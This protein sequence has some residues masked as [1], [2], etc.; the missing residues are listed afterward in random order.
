[1]DILLGKCGLVFFSINWL[2]NAFVKFFQVI[3][4]WVHTLFTNP[5]ISYGLTIIVL[6]LII[7]IVLFPLNYKQI[8]SQVAMT[9]IQP[10]IKKL[11]EKYKNDPQ[12]QQ[13]EMMKLYKEYGVNPLGGCLP[14]LLQWPILI[15]LFYVFNN[16]SKIEPSIVN[17][18][19]LGV[20]LMEPAILK[21]EYWYTWILPIVSALL[22]Y[23]STVIM[24]SKNSDSAQVKQ[25]KMMSGFMTLFVVY[26][27]FKFPT[28][29]VLYWITNSL[30]QIGQTVITQRS[31][32]KKKELVQE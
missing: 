14:L 1:M 8:K 6:T 11:Q 20:K 16:L 4:S 3:H 21:P 28:A 31:Q 23:F 29:L 17:V 24:T 15:A 30:F 10:E 32:Q 25:T 19:F 5:N 9:E 26:M 22:T 12:R 13:Q 2:N 27:S 18:T 7:R